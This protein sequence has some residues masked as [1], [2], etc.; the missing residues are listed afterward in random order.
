MVDGGVLE[1][2]QFCYLG[3]MCWTVKQEWRLREVRARVAAAAWKRWREIA[4]LLD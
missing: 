4:S 3:L 1:E 2:V